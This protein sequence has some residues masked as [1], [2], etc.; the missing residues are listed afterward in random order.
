[1]NVEQRYD[2]PRARLA[3]RMGEAGLITVYALVIEAPGLAFSM[4]WLAGGDGISLHSAFFVLLAI[5]ASLSVFFVASVGLSH[6]PIDR[7]ARGCRLCLW[8]ALSFYLL[9]LTRF[10]FMPAFAEARHGDWETAAEDLGFMSW[11]VIANSFGLPM[12]LGASGGALYGWMRGRRAKPGPK[13]A[14]F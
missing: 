3:A 7:W 2:L 10:A 13:L 8:A 1:V 6:A 4:V 11:A 14:T 12:L 5:A 9:V